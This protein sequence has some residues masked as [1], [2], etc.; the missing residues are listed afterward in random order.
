MI[1]WAIVT[2]V[3]P[4]ALPVMAM[5]CLA[6]FPKLAPDAKA[7]VAVKDGQLCWGAIGMCFSGIYEVLNPPKF[8][9]VDPNLRT[10]SVMA[11]A[12]LLFFSAL[13]AAVGAVSATEVG[14]PRGSVWYKHY[15][16][17]AASLF[18]TICAAIAFA[19]VHFNV[20]G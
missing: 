6:F 16:T 4:L 3:L 19:V 14:V 8:V 10:V 18:L 20:A 7:I 5:L 13:I 17:F 9:A 15:Q 12:L 2:I 1:L 11:F